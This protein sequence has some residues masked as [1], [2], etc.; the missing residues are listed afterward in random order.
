MMM[1][2]I[3][4]GIEKTWVKVFLGIIILSFILAGAL[5]TNFSGGSADAVAK[6]NGEEISTTRWMEG[7]QVEQSRYGSQFE[8][9]H[10]TD[11]MKRQFRINTLDKVINNV[12][13]LQEVKSAGF[14]ASDDQIIKKLKSYPIFQVDGKYSKDRVTEFLNNRNWTES[15]LLNLI[16]DEIAQTQFSKLLID[17][18]FALDYEQ[19]K[20]LQLQQQERDVKSLL[21][22]NKAF[23]KDVNVSDEDVQAYF[24]ENIDQYQVAEKVA[25][26]YLELK[27]EDLL[28]RMSVTDQEVNDYYENNKNK[29][30][31]EEERQVAHILIKISEETTDEQAK[32]KIDAIAERL[33]Q[34][35][36]FAEVAKAESEDTSKDAGGDLGYAG[37]GVMVPEF[38]TAMFA[39]PNVGDISEI[40]KTDFGYHIIKL[41]DIKAGEV[42]PLEEVKDAIV[43]DLKNEKAED[44]FYALK[45]DIETLVYDNYN[46]LT[47]A[48]AKSQLDIKTS[49]PF[50]RTGGTGVFANPQVSTAAFSDAVLNDDRNSDVLD[51]SETHIIVL[52]KK[53]HTPARSKTIDEVKTEVAEAVRLQKMRELAKAKGEAIIAELQAG[54]NASDID[55]G[56]LTWKES[57]NLRRNSSQL[58]YELTG[59]VFEA[60]KPEENQASVSGKQLANGD[61]AVLIVEKVSEP[62]IAKLTDAEK[63][64]SKARVQRAMSD[65]SNSSLLQALRDKA[66]VQK[67]SENIR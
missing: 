53:D 40:V 39:L 48:S 15:H 50:G 14:I 58:G 2:S 28:E 67:F 19:N 24:D 33:K 55:T 1:E 10:P 35:E 52:R 12:A 42:R 3:R 21:I 18:E 30:E 4:S 46:S 27:T 16:N 66:D 51:L 25:V 20:R 8:Q 41:L 29:Y 36:D 17:T 26:D 54:K 9:L 31:T 56:D 60:G 44:E 59:Y 13:L 23:E 62:D 5:T 37:K 64:Q 43:A 57:K 45:S 11:E 22:E 38:E 32:A 49:E 63:Q 65:L 61:F 7:V 6:V 34:G 47:E